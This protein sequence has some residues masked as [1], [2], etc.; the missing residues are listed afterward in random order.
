MQTNIIA[1]FWVVK[2]W[3]M[4]GRCKFR[5]SEWIEYS[6]IMLTIINKI[7]GFKY[8]IHLTPNLHFKSNMKISTPSWTGCLTAC[9]KTSQNRDS[10]ES[11]NS[12]TQISDFCFT[13][14]EM[15]HWLMGSGNQTHWL[16]HN[17]CCV[18]QLT[19]RADGVSS[20]GEE[21]VK[22][23]GGHPAGPSLISGT[24]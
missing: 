12:E 5:L 6:S 15:H 21:C 4:S 10:R 8:S 7:T 18:C 24:C 1:Q 14:T 20:D 9:Q 23:L 16:M 13:T 17:Y 11:C 19:R 22:A 2:N 3:I